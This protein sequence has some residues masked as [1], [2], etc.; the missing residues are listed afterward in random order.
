MTLRLSR[1][2]DT[3]PDFTFGNVDS[4]KSQNLA[5]IFNKESLMIL[6]LWAIEVTLG[7]EMKKSNSLEGSLV[8]PRSRKYQRHRLQKGQEP[9]L[10]WWS[11]CSLKSRPRNEVAPVI[12]LLF[13]S[14][15]EIQVWVRERTIYLARVLDL[16]GQ[17][18]LM[19]KLPCYY[20]WGTWRDRKRKLGRYYQKKARKNQ[21]INLTGSIF[22]II[23]VPIPSFLHNPMLLTLS[24][25]LPSLSY[26]WER[27]EKLVQLWEH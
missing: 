7:T 15:F 2:R 9:E 19:D 22:L 23:I 11:E 1:F 14:S 17:D 24:S 4:E 10:L 5:V 21:Q 3:D 27:T 20:S 6:W 8:F 26:S 16:G 25:V 18:S 12:F 13:I